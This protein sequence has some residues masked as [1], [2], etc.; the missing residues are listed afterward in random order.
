MC[1]VKEHEISRMGA[2][3]DGGHSSIRQTES[4]KLGSI[5]HTVWELTMCWADVNSVCLLSPLI[6]PAPTLEIAFNPRMLVQVTRHETV[7]GV[8][9]SMNAKERETPRCCYSGRR[10]A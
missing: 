3:Q 1:Y 5:S 6:G 4:G 2:G 9:C 10:P 7:F 8:G